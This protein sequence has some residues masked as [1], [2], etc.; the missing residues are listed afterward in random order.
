VTEYDYAQAHGW[1]PPVFFF[2]LEYVLL[3]SILHWYDRDEFSNSHFRVMGMT[4]GAVAAA[5]YIV[6]AHS[7][8]IFSLNSSLGFSY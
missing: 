7:T 4:I 2:G 3:T 1:F 6:D 5:L 8:F